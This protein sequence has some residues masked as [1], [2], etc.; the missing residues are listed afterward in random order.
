MISMNYGCSTSSWKRWRWVSLDLILIIKDIYINSALNPLTKFSSSS[1]STEFKDILL[2]SIS[3][4]IMKTVSVNIRTVHSSFSYY[5][6]HFLIF[7]TVTDL[8][9]ISILLSYRLV[10]LKF[11]IQ[12]RN[13]S[14]Q[15]KY[16]FT[17]LIKSIYIWNRFALSFHLGCTNVCLYYG[18]H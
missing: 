7:I 4:M 2:W 3:Q 6:I 10:S 5:R 1:R 8:I 18:I 16:H 13:D 9:Y 14:W 15:M 11:Y 12:L 17:C